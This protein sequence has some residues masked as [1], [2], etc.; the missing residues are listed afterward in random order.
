[1]SAG[2]TLLLNLFDSYWFEHKIFTP[3]TPF[4]TNPSLNHQAQEQEQE[5]DQYQEPPKLA[6]ITTLMRK[7]YSDQDLSSKDT[8]DSSNSPSPTSVLDGPKLQTIL[9]GKEV[10]NFKEEKQNKTE[11]NRKT[12]ESRRP[13]RRRSSS[14]RSLSELEFEELK[15]FMDMGF[16]FSDDKVDSKLV[17]LVPGLQRLGKK[18]GFGEE[19]LSISRPYLSEAWDCLEDDEKRVK[20]PLM[21]WRIPAFGNEM[22]LKD[23]LRSWAHTVASTVV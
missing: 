13:G 7:S 12:G 1:M 8:S 16:V 18:E 11:R 15:G 22:E 20:N 19:V 17:S 6:R 21:A 3:K 23:H 2:E 10:D 4:E 9:S 5:Q 14:S